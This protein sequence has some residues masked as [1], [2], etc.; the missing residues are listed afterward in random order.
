MLLDFLVQN[1]CGE[2]MELDEFYWRPLHF[3]GRYVKNFHLDNL[4]M[5]MEIVR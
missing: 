1:I 5:I 4:Q 2:T 3:K